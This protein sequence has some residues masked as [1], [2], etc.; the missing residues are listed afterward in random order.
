MIEGVKKLCQLERVF[1]Q[2]SRL[3]GGNALADNIRGLSGRQPEFPDVVRGFA[4]KVPGKLSCREAARRVSVSSARA[5]GQRNAPSRVPT[6]LLRIQ[7][8]FAENIGSA[9]HG[10]LRIRPS[11]PFETQSFLKIEGD[12]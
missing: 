5:R 4:V 2:I 7:P 8:T 6:E 1:G 11:V 12:H 3:G 9:H 10:I